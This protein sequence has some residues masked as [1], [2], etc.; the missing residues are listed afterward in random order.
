MTI[1]DTQIFP[2]VSS[3]RGAPMGR[4]NITDYPTHGSPLLYLRRFHLVDGDYDVGGA[5]WG[6]NGEPM[7]VAFNAAYIEHGDAFGV[8]DHGAV[9]LT[10]RAKNRDDAKRQVREIYPAARFWR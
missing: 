6:N 7:Y 3:S 10:F 8:E 2:N 5:Y 1:T 4:P 9:F